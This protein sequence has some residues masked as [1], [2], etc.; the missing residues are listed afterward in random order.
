MVS[1]YVDL[2]ID[3]F[4]ITKLSLKILLTK[5]ISNISGLIDRNEAENLLNDQCEGTFLVRVSERIWGYAISYRAGD[6]CKHYLVDASSGHYQF[7]G[8]NQISHNTLGK[9]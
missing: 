1:R 7:L 6:R 9:Y 2:T 5:T 8:A 4:I 3:Y